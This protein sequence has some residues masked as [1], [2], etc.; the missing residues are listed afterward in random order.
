MRSVFFKSLRHLLFVAATVMAMPSVSAQS[1]SGLVK[2]LGSFHPERGNVAINQDEEVANLLDT[3]FM[4]NASR[5]G[6]QGYRIRIFFDLSQFSRAESLD[7]MNDFMD[8]YPGIAVYRTFQS[9][10][11]KVSVGDF[12]TRDEAFKL[13]QRLSR[14]Y[15]KAF[16]V[17]E[18]INFPVLD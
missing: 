13:F 3:Y 10:Y 18:W 4:Q 8:Q 2:E 11:Y 14:V 1:G 12:R 16:I 17:S 7:V 15:P 5:P 6:M 9:P